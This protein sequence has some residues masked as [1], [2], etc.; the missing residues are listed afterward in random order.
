ML[1]VL[2]GE[3]V[4]IAKS[5]E[6]F[7]ACVNQREWQEAYLLSELVFQLHEVGKVPGAGQ[8]YALAPHPAIGGP[9]PFFGERIDPRFV[10]VMDVVVWQG[11]CAQFV[12][13]ATNV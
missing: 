10:T 9:N 1:N 3:L 6:E 7:V 4:Q 13:G 8:C 2:S 5:N 12:R 11:I